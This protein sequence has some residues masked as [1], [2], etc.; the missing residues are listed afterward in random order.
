[1]RYVVLCLLLTGCEKYSEP[2]FREVKVVEHKPGIKSKNPTKAYEV[3]PSTIL[4][5]TET[6]RRFEYNKLPNE[7]GSV[8]IINADQYYK[9]AN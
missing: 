3:L 7:V 2:V 9:N 8:L 5:D 4:E 1:M 6:K